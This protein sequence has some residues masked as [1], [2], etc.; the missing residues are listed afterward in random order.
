MQT[1][2]LLVSAVSLGVHIS[3]VRMVAAKTNAM[4]TTK[5]GRK[6]RKFQIVAPIEWENSA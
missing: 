6:T 5:S 4:V 2:V 3:G 1:S